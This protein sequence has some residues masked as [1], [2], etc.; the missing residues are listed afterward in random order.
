MCLIVGVR[1]LDGPVSDR[2]EGE[3]LSFALAGVDV[4]SASWGPNDDG[5][6]VEGPGR[7]AQR[8]LLKGI[9]QASDSITFI[10]L[11][12]PAV[13]SRINCVFTS[14]TFSLLSLLPRLYSI[15]SYLPQ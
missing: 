12:L 10:H 1:M 3:A 14:L 7:L 8:A 2:V 6:T 5:Q 4:Y 9:T 11:H 13:S 15:L